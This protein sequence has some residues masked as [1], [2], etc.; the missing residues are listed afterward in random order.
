MKEKR[1]AKRAA[2]I[3]KAILI[4]EDLFPEPKSGKAKKEWVVQ[5]LNK[6]IDIPLIGEKAEEKLIA[7]TIDV[8][9]DLLFGHG[10]K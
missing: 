7:F 8:V 1:K 6:H 2:I 5:F 3:K 9:H 10:A 4:A